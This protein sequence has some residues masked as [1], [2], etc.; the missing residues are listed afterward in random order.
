MLAARSRRRGNTCTITNTAQPA[1]PTILTIQKVILHDSAN[2]A[3]VRRFAGETALQVT[4]VLYPSLAACNAGTGA[5]G[6]EVRTVTFANGSATSGS[7][8]TVTGVT[9][10]T[11]AGP[12]FW[13]VTSAGN[14]ANALVRQRLRPRTD[15]DY[16]H[17]PVGRSTTLQ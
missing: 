17:L 9:V 14:I 16:V 15:R 10:E 13:K 8:T 11:N 1:Q 2:I 3:G 4:F 7:A 6:S 5:L 12:Y